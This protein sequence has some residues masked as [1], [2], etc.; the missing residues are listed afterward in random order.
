MSFEEFLELFGPP[1]EDTTSKSTLRTKTLDA[2]ALDIVFGVGALN[3]ISVPTYNR[4]R[5][6]SKQYKT[7]STSPSAERAEVTFSTNS[8]NC[9]IKFTM[10]AGSGGYGD[11]D[12]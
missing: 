3:S 10:S 8:S 5:N 2:A 1:N 6:F 11:D 4:P 9:K 7:G 12:W